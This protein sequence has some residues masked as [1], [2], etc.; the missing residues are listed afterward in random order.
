MGV[1]GSRLYQDLYLDHRD[2]MYRAM[3]FIA[4]Q[5]GPALPGDAKEVLIAHRETARDWLLAQREQGDLLAAYARF[6]RL[7][8]P[9]F[10]D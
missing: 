7:W 5:G 10:P 6:L 4:K 8:S 1:K 3:V 2:A 9:V